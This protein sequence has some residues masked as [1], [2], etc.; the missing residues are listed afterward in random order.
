MFGRNVA[1]YKFALGKSLLELSAKGSEFV[2]LEELAEP[3][4]RYLTEHVASGKK[5]ATSKSSRFLDACRNYHNDKITRDQ[6]IT[7][8]VERGFNNVIDAFHVVNREEIPDRFF[9]DERGGKRKGIRLTE[10][11]AGLRELSNP[12]NFV[13]EVE[14][15][16]NLVESAWDMNISHRLLAVQHDADDGQLFVT[17]DFRRVDVTSSRDALNGYQ[18]G[19]CFYCFRDISVAPGSADLAHVDHF[20]PHVLKSSGSMLNVDGVWNLVLAC[21]TCNGMAEKGARVPD[22]P[23]LTRLNRRNEY[24]IASDH[25]LKQTLLM[26][27]GKTQEWR[28]DFLQTAHNEAMEKLIH[29]WCPTPQADSTF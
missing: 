20:F 24:L 25:P 22:T 11:L 9:L 18:K 12:G 1:S 27:V 5:Q 13:R 26:Q 19:R 23:L 7:E 16:W 2:T 21:P 8:T 6:L 17:D 4:S 28:A 10:K 14:S 15:R 29:T 3:F